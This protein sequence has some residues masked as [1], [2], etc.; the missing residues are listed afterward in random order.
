MRITSLIPAIVLVAATLALSGCGL[1]GHGH[2]H[3]GGHGGGKPHA[4][5]DSTATAQVASIS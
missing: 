3:G 1:F 5:L 4:M 2:G